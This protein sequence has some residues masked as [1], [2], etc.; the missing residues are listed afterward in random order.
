MEHASDTSSES[1]AVQIELLR[2]MS[3]QQ[4]LEKTLRWSRQLK[5]MATDAIRRRYPE[6]D[7]AA[8]RL[9]FVELTYGEHLANELRRWQEKRDVGRT[10]RSY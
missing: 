4:R 10:R 7:E 6:L 8:I 5:E 2:Q 1:Y 3:P 9:K